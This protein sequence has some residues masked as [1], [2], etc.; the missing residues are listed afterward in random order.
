MNSIR[1]LAL[2][3]T[4]VSLVAI[5]FGQDSTRFSTDTNE[6]WICPRTPWGDPDLQGT[7]TSD[8][9]RV[10]PM[11]RPAQNADRLYLTEDE[12]RLRVKSVERSRQLIDTGGA[13][14]SPALGQAETAAKGVIILPPPGPLGSGVDAASVPPTCAEFARRAS[15]QTSL[16]LIPSNGRIPALTPEAQQRLAAKSA[17]RSRPPESWEDWSL[18][19]RCI[20]RGVVGS[21]LPVIYGNGLE[22]VQAPGYVAIRYEMVHETRMIPLNVGSHLASKIRSYMGDPIGHW[23]GKSLVVDTTNFTD[24]TAIGFNGDSGPPHS[25]AMHLVERFTRSRQNT[26]EYEVTIDDPQTY[27]AKWKIAFPI[28]QEPGY[29]IFEYACHEGNRAMRNALGAARAEDANG[30]HE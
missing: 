13:P 5:V 16:V 22:I 18:Y 8:D 29:R 1:M 21:I 25:E 11:E 17:I 20:T 28:T 24:Q 12:F 10:V 3:S 2:T 26:I 30:K 23:D 15:R 9:A 4:L 7:W 27:T 6:G 19:D 14:H